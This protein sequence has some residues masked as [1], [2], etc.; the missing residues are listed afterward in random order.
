MD[1]PVNTNFS[2]NVNLPSGI[3]KVKINGLSVPFGI[4][5]NGGDEYNIKVDGQH[6]GPVGAVLKIFDDQGNEVAAFN[7]L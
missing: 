6:V 1:I 5:P 3:A 7:I 4:A 2:T